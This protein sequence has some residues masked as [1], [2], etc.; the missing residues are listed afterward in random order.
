MRGL[1]PEDIYS[2]KWAGDPR[3]SPDGQRIAYVVT[4]IDKEDN[5][6]RPQ[7]WMADVGQAAEPRPFSSGK[8][9]ESQ[10]RWSP[11]GKR[12]AFVAHHSDDGGELM[13]IPSDGGEAKEILHLPESIA[14]LSWSPDGTRIAFLA[15]ARNEE[16]YGKEK[17][18]DRPPRR[19]NRLF[20]RLDN[21]GWT[22]DRPTQLFVVDV[23][24]EKPEPRQL[25][26]GEHP[27][28]G[29]AWSPDGSEI[30]FASATHDTWDFDLLTDLFVIDPNGGEPER[31]TDT[32][33][34]YGTPSWGPDGKI[35]F[36]WTPDSINGPWHSRLGIIDRTSRKKTILTADLDLQAQPYPH[37]REPIWNEGRIWFSVEDAGNV[38]AYSIIAEEG[39]KPELCVGGAGG[40]AGLDV[41]GQ[42]L[43]Y[44]KS[45]PTRLAALYVS[46]DDAVSDVT[47]SSSTVAIVDNEFAAN[48][49]LQA[50]ERFTAI[51]NDGTEVEAW[52]VRPAGFKDGEIYPTLLSIHG[53]PFTQYSNKFFDEF[54]CYSG[55]GYAVVYCNPRGSSGYSERWGRCIRGPK[56]EDPG[57]GW[58]SVDYEDLM[59]V[60]EEA[61]TRF[62][63]VDAERLGVLGGSY[64][65]YMT[66]WI[67]GHNDKFKAAISERAVNNMLTMAHTADVATFFGRELGP[68]YLDDPDEYLK[69]S[70]IT[71][72]RN[73]NTPVLV[74]HSENDLRC[75]IEQAEQ[76]YMALKMLGKEVEF[77]R[78]PGEGHELSRSGAPLHR[79]QRFEIIIE[80]FDRYLK[81]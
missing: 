74:M 43:A 25:T 8:H 41:K 39:A 2:L 44:A 28:D 55:A 17:D 51:S 68:S 76:L 71:Y 1:I 79:V 3:I 40:I 75:P 49:K 70:P 69:Y 20:Y 81:G 12:I 26:H 50:P 9:K 80:W 30:A 58:G 63:F 57:S 32:D 34:A 10:P 4:S 77:V 7:I 5:E 21:V 22:I 73:I 6:Y 14:D 48:L 13:L 54:H 37:Y 18:K 42:T 60:I 46:K 62:S 24:A 47:D 15:R 29:I 72:V 31:L 66:T 36:Y 67:I 19:I 61:A 16:F 65:G 78:F 53:G 35:A 23:D 27:V 52:I 64:G 59:A 38:H 11:D 45:T 56:T 33:S